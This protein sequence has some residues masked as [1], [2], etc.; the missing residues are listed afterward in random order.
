M[1]VDLKVTARQP[2]QL[3]DLNQLVYAFHKIHFKRVQQFHFPKVMQPCDKFQILYAHDQRQFI[4]VPH[5]QA[6]Q[7]RSSE[8]LVFIRYD[9]QLVSI[10]QIALQVKSSWNLNELWNFS[11]VIMKVFHF[12][13]TNRYSCDLINVCYRLAALHGLLLRQGRSSKCQ[14][15]LPGSQRWLR[16]ALLRLTPIDPVTHGMCS[17]LI[18]CCHALHSCLN[19][20]MI[21]WRRGYELA[22]SSRQRSPYQAVLTNELRENLVFYQNEIPLI[23]D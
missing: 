2:I 9:L 8:K 11:L 4:Q 17:H 18:F 16:G 7:D 13:Y 5:L 22:L 15:L 20:S 3:Q 19:S 10:L 14:L 1:Q 21:R 6:Y 23:P 12:D